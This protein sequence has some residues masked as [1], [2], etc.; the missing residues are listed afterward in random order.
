[1]Q[2]KGVT[3]KPS[4]STCREASEKAL[5]CAT[6]QPTED[7]TACNDLFQAY[8]DCRKI[9]HESIVAERIAKRQSVF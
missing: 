2:Q 8:K 5:A 3:S 4:Q 7:K 6:R 1:M 9:E